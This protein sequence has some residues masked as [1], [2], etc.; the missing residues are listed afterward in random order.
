MS[1][2]FSFVF[3]SFLLVLMSTPAS[4]HAQESVHLSSEQVRAAGVKISPAKAG[5]T[6]DTIHA[7][8]TVHYDEYALA[9]VTTLIKA[10]IHQRHVHLGDVVHKGDPLITLKSTA[11]AHAEASWLHAQASYEKNR[12]EW[13]RLRQLVKDGIVSQARFQQ[14]QSD[15]MSTRAEKL[16]ARATLVS[17]GLTG[18]DIGRLDGKQAFGLITLRAPISGVV[19]SDKFVLGQYVSPGTRLMRISDVS[20]VWVEAN[21][22]PD[23]FHLIHKGDETDVISKGGEV[24]S[25]G[26][27]VG[28]HYELDA[29]TRTALVRIEVD[30]RDRKFN[31]GMFVNVEIR[32]GG[33]GRSKLLIPL[34][35]V[36]QQGEEHVVFVQK[37]PGVFVLRKVEIRSAGP[38]MVSVDSGLKA[39]EMVVT[40]GTFAVLSELL[41]AGFS[42]E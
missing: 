16:A 17:Y 9:D 20:T 12:L 42:D 24:Q 4:V 41:K 35:A 19:G 36:Q 40:N 1:K 33:G 34:S 2:P 13:L 32:A 14:A 30:N 3:V 10:Q 6:T 28:V 23:Q 7:P 27:V 39:G 15:Y 8:G 37:S 11:L 22:P 18:N 25:S 26:K 38:G 29:S 21:V 5:V 31:P